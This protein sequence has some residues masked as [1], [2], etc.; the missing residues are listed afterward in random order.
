MIIL[1]INQILI[2][3]LNKRPEAMAKITGSPDY[4]EVSGT[5]YFYA[6][7]YGVMVASIVNNLPEKEGECQGGVFGFHIHEGDSCS[8]DSTD[9]FKDS[10]GHYNPN[11]C[12]H[13]HHAGDMPPLFDADE[14]AFLM[15]LTDRFSIDEIIGKTVVIHSN[16]DD[17]TTQPSGNSGTKIACGKIMAI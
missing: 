10:L 2:S 7:N 16:P 5:V 3:L 4:A 17:F 1:N 9:Y 12:P 13:P 14:T 11:N 6:T 8:G 15:F